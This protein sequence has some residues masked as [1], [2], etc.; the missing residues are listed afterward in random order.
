MILNN[1][2]GARP[3][4][5]NCEQDSSVVLLNNIHDLIQE[6]NSNEDVEAVEAT[7]NELYNDIL[8]DPQFT[9]TELTIFESQSLSDSSNLICVQILE[10][11]YCESCRSLLRSNTDPSEQ[12]YTEELNERP[13][14]I[15]KSHCEQIFEFAVQVIPL[16]CCEKRIKKVVIEEV[17]KKIS[18]MNKNGPQ[19]GCVKHSP[20]ISGKLYESTIQYALTIFCKDLNDIITGKVKVLPNEPN[21]MQ[22]QA[23]LFVSKN[24]RIGKFSDIF[25]KS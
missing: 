11:A 3:L 9:K 2:T 14:A 5:T 19:L 4:S 22:E 15:F 24:S 13:S 6:F 17:K 16:F 21:V 1:L 25:L 7:Q 12:S 20:E 10:K 23:H 18:E 8:C